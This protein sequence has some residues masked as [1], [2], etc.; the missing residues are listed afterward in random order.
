MVAIPVDVKSSTGLAKTII[1]QHDI[2]DWCGV[3]F[4]GFIL[5]VSEG[6]PSHQ[7][8]RGNVIRNLCGGKKP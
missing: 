8:V 3:V 7:T 1:G 6:I 2:S 4:C 5:E